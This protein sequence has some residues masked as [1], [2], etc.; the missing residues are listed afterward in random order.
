MSRMRSTDRPPQGIG[1]TYYPGLLDYASLEPKE[2]RAA[3]FDPQARGL[4][5]IEP[6]S[7][8]AGPGHPGNHSVIG[9]N[10]F[11][12]PVVPVREALAE[13]PRRMP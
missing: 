1:V 2:G 8:S 7:V 3:I 13:R 4:N 6:S 11:L 10:H 12:D 5:V 9:G